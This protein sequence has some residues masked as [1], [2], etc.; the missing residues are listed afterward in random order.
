MSDI[1]YQIKVYSYIQYNVGLCSPQSDIGGPDIR[2]SPIS[3]I[4]D[5]Q[6]GAHLRL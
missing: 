1:R 5:I 6:L 3:P 2:L 4:M